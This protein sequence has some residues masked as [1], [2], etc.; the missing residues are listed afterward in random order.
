MSRIDDELEK[1]LEESEAAA[2]GS[3]DGNVVPPAIAEPAEP[4][5][6][7]LGLLA[8]LLVMGAGILGL[9]LF[10]VDDA[11]I[12]SKSVDELLAAKSDLADRKVNVQ[13][14]LVKGTLKRRDK[15]CEY[16]FTM[17]K[18]GQKLPVRYAQCVIP[19]TFRDV[20]NVDV[21]VTAMGMLAA[22]GHFEAEQ[23]MAKC[24]SKY[25]MKERAAKG[26]QAPHGQ[27]T[28][29]AADEDMPRL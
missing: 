22:D 2:G 16:R 14:T 20:P 7:H 10:S 13:G 28:P 12:Y 9:V 1:A 27:V 19:D 8:A 25:D 17:E 18:N 4:P 3:D 24:P 21:Q 29:S 6:R 23:I 11:A 5:K 26:E 15:P